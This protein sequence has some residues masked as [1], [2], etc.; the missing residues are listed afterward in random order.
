MPRLTVSAIITGE[1]GLVGDRVERE[2]AREEEEE[3]VGRAL[4]DAAYRV[5]CA[6][7]SW[8]RSGLHLPVRS[9]EVCLQRGWDFVG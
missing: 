1:F 9:P 4:N 5:P 8:W 7:S 2:G 6:T 3:R